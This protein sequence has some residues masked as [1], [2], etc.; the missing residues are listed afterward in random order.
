MKTQV[1]AAIIGTLGI[2]TSANCLAGWD[3]GPIDQTQTG[4][5]ALECT[6][7]RFSALNSPVFQT[8]MTANYKGESAQNNFQVN[9]QTFA[10]GSVDNKQQVSF[11]ILGQTKQVTAQVGETVEFVEPTSRVDKVACKYN[12]TQRQ[13]AGTLS[14][15]FYNTNIDN[16]KRTALYGSKT[17]SY[18]N[19]WSQNFFQQYS[20]S[21][22][23]RAP[24]GKIILGVELTGYYVYQGPYSR[25]WDEAPFRPDELGK[26]YLEIKANSTLYSYTVYYTDAE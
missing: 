7:T 11:N 17:V 8:S 22:F 12:Y 20:N 13:W 18:R 2:L 24:E 16:E 10:S 19:V 5:P 6:Y 25:P 9:G 4:T 3:D 15:A 26:N 14:Q 23:V 21:A 1:I